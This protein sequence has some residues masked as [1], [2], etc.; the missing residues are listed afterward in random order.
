M[1]GRTFAKS[2]NIL[3]YLH[4]F[5]KQK[6]A[7][8]FYQHRCEIIRNLSHELAKQT[9]LKLKEKKNLSHQNINCKV[10]SISHQRSD[11]KLDQS[12][13]MH[14]KAKRIQVCYL[15]VIF[16]DLSYLDLYV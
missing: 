5:L 2:I 8:T 3:E 1:T 16:C 13:H 4:P 10:C 11:S 15:L 12:D 7:E 6:P 9:D 14:L